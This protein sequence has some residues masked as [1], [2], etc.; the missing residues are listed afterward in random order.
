MAYGVKIECWGPYACFTRPEMKVERVSY[1]VMTP[2][3]ARGL[4]EAIF[5]HPGLKYVIDEIDLLSP[6]RYTNIRRNEVKSKIL[7][8][9]AASAAKAHKETYLCTK[10]DIQQRAAEVLKDVKY[11]IHV[12]FEMTDRANASDNPGKF[13]EMLCRRARRGSAITSPIWDAGN[14]RR[15]SGW[16]RMMSR[17]CLTRKP[18]TW[19]ICSTIWISLTGSI[20]FL[21][22]SMPGWRRELWIS[23]TA[24]CTDDTSIAGTFI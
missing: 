15:D 4:V 8:S 23:G 24:R 22:S 17:W 5:W 18:G 16:W 1:D 13:R 6:I 9:S 20:L 2:S 7:A 11:C 3:A 21:N 10:A 19:D 12:H 14:F